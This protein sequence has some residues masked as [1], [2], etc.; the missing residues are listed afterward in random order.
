MMTYTSRFLAALAA[1]VLCTS[2]NEN[3]VTFPTP[4]PATARI[5]NV[6]SDVDTLTVIVDYTTTVKIPHGEASAPI[7]FSSG[8]PTPFVLMEGDTMLRRDTLYYTFGS[9]ASMVMYSKGTKTNTVE[10]LRAVPDTGVD[11]SSGK[12]YVRFSHMATERP[13]GE[14]YV[15]LRLLPKDSVVLASMEP[16]KT[17]QF[18]IAPGTYSFASVQ[19]GT[20]TTI[21]TLPAQ[22]FRAGVLY[23]IYL[24]FG[25]AVTYTEPTMKIFN[26]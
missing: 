6:T 26:N 24:Y 17:K 25:N 19:E 15:D 21:A 2:C 14:P 5:V 13:D 16:G 22:E 10:F 8:R 1:L 12:A 4:T 18:S 23:T 3:T 11:A 20:T 9:G 7:S